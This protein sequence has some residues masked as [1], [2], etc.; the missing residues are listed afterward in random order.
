MGDNHFFLDIVTLIHV[1]FSC[2]VIS[3]QFLCFKGC[4]MED[5]QMKKRTQ[6]NNESVNEG[7]TMP[8]EQFFGYSCIFPGIVRTITHTAHHRIIQ[9]HG[10]LVLLLVVAR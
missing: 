2:A 9:L 6:F 7:R 8:V 10:L 3:F 5:Y 4:S 1:S